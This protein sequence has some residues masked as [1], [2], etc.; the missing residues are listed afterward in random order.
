MRRMPLLSESDYALRRFERERRIDVLDDLFGRVAV[1]GVVDH[2]LDRDASAAHDWRTG[3]H[4]RSDFNIRRAGPIN[5][6][7]LPI[8]QNRA[9]FTLIGAGISLI[10]AEQFGVAQKALGVILYSISIAAVVLTLA[11]HRL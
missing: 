4:I 6:H 2:A 9:V 1:L 10:V 7:S 5:I 8:A 11:G 3:H